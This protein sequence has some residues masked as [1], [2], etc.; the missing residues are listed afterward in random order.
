MAFV[1]TVLY[2]QLNRAIGQVI[3]RRDR[4]GELEETAHMAAV[5]LT[6]E[7]RA[8]AGQKVTLMKDVL[9]E[10]SDRDFEILSRFYLREQPPEQVCAEMG[11]PKSSSSSS[12][13]EPRHGWRTGCQETRAEPA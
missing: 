1:R 8:I 7:Q 9:R 4:S 2:R 6:P 10:M 13:Q 12:N 5:E 3:Q 11:F